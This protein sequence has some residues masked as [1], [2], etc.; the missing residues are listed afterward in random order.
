MKY[1]SVSVAGEV[2]KTI[3]FEYNRVEELIEYLEYRRWCEDGCPSP[4]YEDEPT[5]N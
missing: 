4:D 5:L 1:K 3:E 2:E